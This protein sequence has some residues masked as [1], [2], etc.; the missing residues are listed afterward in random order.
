MIGHKSGL[1]FH[2]TVSAKSDICKMVEFNA[3]FI[4]IFILCLVKLCRDIGN[5]V[6]REIML[7][8][9]VP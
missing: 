3:R 9:E 2:I 7:P 1:S 8:W 5:H 4:E 6:H